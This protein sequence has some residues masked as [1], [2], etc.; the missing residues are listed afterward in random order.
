VGVAYLAIWRAADVGEGE[1]GVPGP[2]RARVVALD[3][4]SGAV[5]AVA[6]LAGFPS[7]LAYVP[8]PAPEDARLYCLEHVPFPLY[9]TSDVTRSRLLALDPVTLEPEREL[10]PR[11]SPL[12]VAVAPDGERAYALASGGRELVSIDLVTVAVGPPVALPGL[13]YALAVTEAWVYVSYL[14]GDAVWLLDRRRCTIAR[15]VRVD[16]QPTALALSG[17]A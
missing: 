5:R 12:R 9:D 8:G 7:D 2:G 17:R 3:A 1:G 6:P 15:T 14:R 16:G 10:P 4:G 13:R 11:D